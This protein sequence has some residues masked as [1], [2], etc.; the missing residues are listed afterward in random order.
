[1]MQ[2]VTNEAVH[3]ILSENPLGLIL[4]YDELAGWVKNF[5]R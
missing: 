4:M 1:M 3:R 2:D 5:N